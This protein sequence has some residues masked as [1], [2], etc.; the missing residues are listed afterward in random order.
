ML[1]DGELEEAATVAFF[2]TVQNEDERK[3]EGA[4]AANTSKQ[5]RNPAFH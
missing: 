5:N 2:A 4:I 1:E 3:V